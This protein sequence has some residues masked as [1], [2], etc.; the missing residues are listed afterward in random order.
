ML[1]LSNHKMIKTLKRASALFFFIKI[2][3]IFIGNNNSL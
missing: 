3:S 2:F 1:T